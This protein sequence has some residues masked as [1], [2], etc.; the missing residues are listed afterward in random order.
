MPKTAPRPPHEVFREAC[1]IAHAKGMFIL[2]K[3]DG[4]KTDYIVCRKLPN[5]RSTRLTTRGSVTTLHRY[6]VDAAK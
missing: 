4:K 6:V 2:K 1:Q 5:G 3:D